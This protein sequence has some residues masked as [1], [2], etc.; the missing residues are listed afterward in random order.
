MKARDILLP[1]ENP[2]TLSLGPQSFEDP[3]DIIALEAQRIPF[4]VQSPNLNSLSDQLR[5]WP[6]P[7]KGWDT[8]YKRVSKQHYATRQPAGIANLLPLSL[9]QLEKQENMLKI[10]SYFWSDALNCFFF[11]HAPMTP[12]LMDATMLT[13]LDITFI[14][15]SAFS[16]P[17]CTHQIVD[18]ATTKNWS[19]YIELYAKIKGTV[20]SREHTAFLNLWLDHFVFCGLL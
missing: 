10:L 11:G 4:V 14:C 12:T 9:A 2:K 18:K 17:K 19:Q 15:P 5:A 16:L 20:D 1:T 6:H 3:S 13:G 7:V 8:W